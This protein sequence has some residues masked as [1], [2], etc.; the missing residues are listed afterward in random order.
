MEIGLDFGG[1][2]GQRRADVIGDGW[3]HGTALAEPKNSLH[4]P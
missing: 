2:A 4:A 3:R 1:Q